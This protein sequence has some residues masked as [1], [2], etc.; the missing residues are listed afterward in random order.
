MCALFYQIKY[1]GVGSELADID[2]TLSWAMQE[3]SFYWY[4]DTEM[5]STNLK[6]SF[7]RSEVSKLKVYTANKLK[8]SR[9]EVL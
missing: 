4:V 7:I 2:G 1:D 5:N 3:E 6:S 9:T 8:Y